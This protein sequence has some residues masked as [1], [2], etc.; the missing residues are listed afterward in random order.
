[1]RRRSVCADLRVERQ[2]AQAIGLCC[3][4]STLRFSSWSMNTK[5]SSRFLWSQVFLLMTGFPRSH[6]FSLIQ[7]SSTFIYVHLTS[8]TLQQQLWRFTQCTNG[9]RF[10]HMLP[11]MVF[12]LTKDFLNRTFSCWP[13]PYFPWFDLR[14]RQNVLNW[15]SRVQPGFYVITRIGLCRSASG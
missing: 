4:L 5:V 15:E 7:I 11:I 10:P 6:L 1:M 12:I 2:H 13:M 8:F 9:P 3:T 14:K